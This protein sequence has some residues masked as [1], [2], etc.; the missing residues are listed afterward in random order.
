MLYDQDPFGRQLANRPIPWPLPVDPSHRVQKIHPLLSHFF[1]PLM[2]D[3]TSYI[4]SWPS[5]KDTTAFLAFTVTSCL[6]RGVP[7][8]KVATQIY[9]LEAPSLETNFIFAI[10][11]V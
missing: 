5:E 3:L 4:G 1:L 11:L 2:G 7:S 9:S 10:D 8:Q 6:I